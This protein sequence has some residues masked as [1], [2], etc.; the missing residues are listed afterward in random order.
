[1][2]LDTGAA[3]TALTNTALSLAGYTP[4]SSSPRTTVI[5][6]SRI[7]QWP[8]ARVRQFATFGHV[9]TDFQV[10]AHNLPMGAGV[11][12]VVGLDFFAGRKLCID[13]REG[14]LELT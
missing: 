10:L 4:G 12:G 14:I 7:E 13:L 5:T 11:D 3:F 9:R 2:I 6:A 1:M 8:V